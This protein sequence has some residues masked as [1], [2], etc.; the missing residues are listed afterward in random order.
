[1]GWLKAV[2]NLPWNLKGPLLG[3]VAVVIAL[4]VTLTVVI[5]TGGDDGMGD[6]EAAQGP[7]STATP[8]ASPTPTPSPEPTPPTLTTAE[9]VTLV[10]KALERGELRNGMLTFPYAGLWVVH[11]SSCTATW[12]KGHWWVHCDEA[13]IGCPPGEVCRWIEVNVCLW[14]S[15][16]Q[17][18]TCL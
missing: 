13:H 16:L 7:R 12:E 5:A 8:E 10:V 3:V 14:E 17:V 6:S 15:P 9:V 18:G 2:W 11:P 4:A 1:M